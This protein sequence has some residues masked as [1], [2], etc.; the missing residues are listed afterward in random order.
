MTGLEQLP[1]DPFYDE[2]SCPIA[3]C[4]TVG[5]H[6]HDN[7]DPRLPLNRSGSA[8]DLTR[9]QWGIYLTTGELPP[10]DDLPPGGNPA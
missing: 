5:Q 4:E 2:T 8:I 10:V 3:T 7:D 6:V 1:P 9:D